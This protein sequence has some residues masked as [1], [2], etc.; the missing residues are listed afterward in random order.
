MTTVTSRHPFHHIG[1]EQRFIVLAES[2]ELGRPA[3]GLAHLY[4]PCKSGN[5]EID[6]HGRAG[7]PLKP[8]FGL[9]GAVQSRTEK[10][11]RVGQFLKFGM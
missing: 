6:G 2:A 3:A 4:V 10:F 11:G 8:A 1:S 9:S 7:G 5:D